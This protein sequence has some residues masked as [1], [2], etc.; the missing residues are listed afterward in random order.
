MKQSVFF[1]LVSAT[2]LFAC[3]E[4]SNE[5]APQ[6]KEEPQS[7][8]MPK[9]GTTHETE[10]SPDGTKIILLNDKQELRIFSAENGSVL[11]T[12]NVPEA[13][14]DVD[15]SFD[16]KSIVGNSK[17]KIYIWRAEDLIL[18]NTIEVAVDSIRLSEQGPYVAAVQND[19]FRIW[20]FET[21]EEMAELQ[22]PKEDNFRKLH[23]LSWSNERIPHK[24]HFQFWSLQTP[25]GIELFPWIGG[26]SFTENRVQVIDPVTQ[27]EMLS[28]EF[29]LYGFPN[30]S[31]NNRWVIS[32]GKHFLSGEAYLL[33]SKLNACETEC[34]GEVGLRS[35]RTDCNQEDTL[36]HLGS[37]RD[38]KIS[39][40]NE[41]FLV[42]NDKREILVGNLNDLKQPMKTI[43]VH[44]QATDIEVPAMEGSRFLTMGYDGNVNVWDVKTGSLVFILDGTKRINEPNKI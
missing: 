26:N 19:M 23:F 41:S 10:L 25:D 35:C 3:H 12:I 36:L 44:T 32:N 16:G 5:Q 24:E 17:S 39:S 29:F 27:D 11:Y 22:I 30:I 38:V 33:F 18:T 40:D 6:K 15:V 31:S 1:S 21:G 34:L 9:I 28:E 20:N 7:E 13:I 37:T 43:G 2:F 4:A 14:S 42:I 8:Q